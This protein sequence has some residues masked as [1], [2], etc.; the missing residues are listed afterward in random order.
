MLGEAAEVFLRLWGLAELRAQPELVVNQL[1]N[2][3]GVRG[4]KRVLI[5]EALDRHGL[6]EAP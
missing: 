3:V 1:E 6:P 4:Q 5:E 2:G